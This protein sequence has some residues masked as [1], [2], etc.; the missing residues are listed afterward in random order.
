MRVSLDVSYL[1]ARI[2][3][4]AASSSL[5]SHIMRLLLIHVCTSVR[6]THINSYSNVVKVTGVHGGA[7]V[8]L[9]VRWR[10]QMQ[11]KPM[12]MSWRL[13]DIHCPQIHVTL[14]HG[15]F[16]ICKDAVDALNSLLLCSVIWAV[17]AIFVTFNTVHSPPNSTVK[18]EFRDQLRLTRF[19][20]QNIQGMYFDG[21]R[22][23]PVVA[24]SGVRCLIIKSKFGDWTI[25]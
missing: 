11:P 14:E 12:P 17:V 24:E 8:G 5:S 15:R 21:F 23:C 22:F 20:L 3:L 2:H 18:H 13:K 19:S 7:Q 1:W 10:C 16:L 9:A 6:N 4:H 25:T